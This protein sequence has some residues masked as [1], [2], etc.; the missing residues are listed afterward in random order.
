MA[1]HHGVTSLVFAHASNNYDRRRILWSDLMNIGD[2]NIC[3]L[4]DFNVVLGTHE[5][6][7]GHLTHATPSDEFKDFIS[8]R[9]LFDIEGIGNKYTWATRQNRGFIAARLDRA[10]ASQGFLN[11]WDDVKLLILPMH[12]SDHSPLRFHAVLNAPSSPRPFRF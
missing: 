4:G 7:S 1:I 3:I 5:C 2:P 10:L 9:D 11:L 12:C 6:S 8:G